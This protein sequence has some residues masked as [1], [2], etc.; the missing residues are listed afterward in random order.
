MAK[1][2]DT[3]VVIVGAGTSGC[4]LAW[5]LATAGRKC[6]VVEGAPLAEL[7]KHI[8][9][10]HM[11]E[12]SFERFDIPLPE[13]DE[14]LHREE[15]M[16]MWS[17]A[18]EHSF[19][20][21][22]PTMVMDKP[23]F[24]R[25]LAGY[26]VD[27][28]AEILERAGVHGLVRDGGY[29]RGV[30]AH[31]E[32]GEIEVRGRLVIDASGIDAVV[33]TRLPANRWY[34]S[35]P[36]SARDTIFVYMETWR[37]LKGDVPEGIYSYP[38]FQGWCAPGP[39][40][41]RI[42]GIGMTGSYEAARRRHQGFVERLPFTG[43]VVGSTTGRI[44]YRHPPFSLVDNG[45]MVA[46]DAAYMNKPFSGEGVTSA[47]AGCLAAI[48][49]AD[50]ALASD[51]CTRE[52]LWAYN[53]NYFTDQGA[54]FAFIMAALPALMAVS[55]DEM[56]LFFAT[57][58][59]LSERAALAMQ[60]E[61]EVE[62]DVI[63][64]LKALPRLGRGLAGRQLRASSLVNVARAGAMAAM[65]KNL[66]RKFPGHPMDFTRW[67]RMVVPLWRGVDGGRYR[68]FERVARG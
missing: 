24:M 13:G 56:E 35:E 1:R 6:I 18:L 58:G 15:D 54:K 32:G 16:T 50:E 26:A 12:V 53:T 43:E 28:G 40:D 14:L 25:R 23:L 66:Y 49:A 68:Y 21:K 20:F 67:L 7:G 36:I 48:K 45:L 9:P 59:L 63:T 5:K 51:D 61:Y 3:D 60:L 34:E 27:A 30:K 38:Y 52:A 65:L 4:Y 62:Q 8:G 17:P 31:G 10:F 57:P 64:G 42:V 29:L 11:E 46:G 37:D 41:T 19:H 2:M 55:E 47:F 39:G 44:P 22:F 33:R